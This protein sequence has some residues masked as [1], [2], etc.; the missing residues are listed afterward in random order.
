MPLIDVQNEESTII[1]HLNKGQYVKLAELYNLESQFTHIVRLEELVKSHLDGVIQSRLLHLIGS[2]GDNIILINE[3]LRMIQGVKTLYGRLEKRQIEQ[4][5]AVQ[6][7]LNLSDIKPEHRGSIEFIRGIIDGRV[8]RSYI[9]IKLCKF[10]WQG[11]MQEFE[12]ESIKL[13]AKFDPKSFVNTFLLNT[14]DLA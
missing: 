10:Y 5:H 6:L 11:K 12:S 8:A 3:T 1:T 4:A 14:P 2:D 9:A 13:E 7:E